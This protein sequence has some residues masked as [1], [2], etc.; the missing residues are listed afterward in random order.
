M[1]KCPWN[2][3][4]FLGKI[5]EGL[6]TALPLLKKYKKNLFTLVI[7]LISITLVLNIIVWLCTLLFKGIAALIDSYL[8]YIIIIAAIVLMCY[9]ALESKIE[10]IREEHKRKNAE[11]LARQQKNA[12]S[13]YVYLRM[14]MYKILDERLCSLCEIVKPITPN[15]LN[16]ITPM[17]TNNAIIFY[18]FQVHKVKTVPFSQ[19]TEYVQSLITSRVTAKIQMEGIEGI[20]AAVRDSLLTPAYVDSVKDLGMTA[21]ITLALD[22]EAYRILKEKQQTVTPGD[23]IEHI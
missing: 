3:R 6:K 1:F 14:F 20:T 17:D 11:E 12:N 22:S 8:Y 18:H 5:M 9:K 23:L 10:R 2:N 21:L 15:S 13:E 4:H 16:A 7:S 19:G